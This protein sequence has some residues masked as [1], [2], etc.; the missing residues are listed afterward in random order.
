MTRDS[1][2]HGRPNFLMGKVHTRYCGLVL[3]SHVEN[4]VVC[5]TSSV[6]VVDALGLETHAVKGIAR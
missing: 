5:V 1:V 3:G 6:I 2:N 4:W